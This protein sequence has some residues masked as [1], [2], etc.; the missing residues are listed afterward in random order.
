MKSQ[1]PDFNYLN[2]FNY[3]N[4]YQVY[5][6]EVGRQI[7]PKGAS[8]IYIYICTH[9]LSSVSLYMRHVASC[10]ELSSLKQVRTF[11]GHT[12]YDVDEALAKNKGGSG[13]Y[14]STIE[15]VVSSSGSSPTT[16]NGMQ[17]LA[18]ALV[19]VRFSQES[20]WPLACASMSIRH[21]ESLPPHALRQENCQ[22]PGAQCQRNDPFATPG[23]GNSTHG[24]P[25]ELCKSIEAAAALA[26]YHDCGPS[27]NC[28]TRP[29][30]PPAASGK[31]LQQPFAAL[32]GFIPAVYKYWCMQLAVQ[33]WRELP[34]G[35]AYDVP[36]LKKMGWLPRFTAAGKAGGPSSIAD[37]LEATNRALVLAVATA[38]VRVFVVA[39]RQQRR[40]WARPADLP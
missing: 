16:N 23:T 38:A 18:K 19:V 32:H 10:T 30:L 14:A 27:S 7:D 26:S 9:L 12:L 31:V 3:L 1:F 24:S 25:W 2:Y 5:R 34:S 35:Q 15:Y 6:K 40:M 33:I 29:P 11:S 22:S 8:L 28:Q 21:W 39:L 4:S 20:R 37:D 17:S 13:R 36:D